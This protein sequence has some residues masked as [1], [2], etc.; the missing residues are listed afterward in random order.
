VGQPE[1]E[2]D[3][4]AESVS[5]EGEYLS[6]SIEGLDIVR[7]E[8]RSQSRSRQKRMQDRF[9]RIRRARVDWAPHSNPS[10]NERFLEARLSGERRRYNMLGDENMPLN[11]VES[12]C[13]D[14][15]IDSPVIRREFVD[16]P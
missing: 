9:E 14:R 1:R 6:D 10:L 16:S 3:P 11:E 2:R 13:S 15:S 7:Y 12:P 4:E 5:G 8:L